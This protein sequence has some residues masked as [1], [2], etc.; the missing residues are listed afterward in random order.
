VLCLVLAVLLVPAAATAADVVVVKSRKF[1]LYDKAVAGFTEVYKGATTTI[2]MEKRGPLADP[3]KLA[4]AV[5]KERPKV[6]LAVGLQA[7]KSLKAEI[8]DIPIVFCM[9]MHPVQNKL[10]GR[11]TTGV[12]LEPWPKEQLQA[13]RSAIPRLKRLGII[14]DPDRTGRF[15][16][17][18]KVAAT[19]LGMK[20]VARKVDDR[21]EVL[22]ALKALTKESDALWL[23]RDATVLT[24]EFFNHTLIVQVE[25]KLPL[26]AYSPQFVKKGAVC[27]YATDYPSQGRKAAELVKQILGGTDPADIPI[28]APAGRLT[29]NMDSASKAGVK[30]P[31]AVLKQPGVRV[32]R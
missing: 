14:Y 22:G 9:A 24:R 8:S 1:A 19:S 30:I 31:E 27:S 17:Q 6:I 21:K 28:Q 16:E 25:E 23:I 18:A 11:N 26:L 15:V 3:S 5:R 10:K 29:I 20:L 32:L 2:V 13:F 12:E 7:A 4:S